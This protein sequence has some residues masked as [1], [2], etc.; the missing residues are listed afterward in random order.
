MGRPAMTEEEK[1]LKAKEREE[2]KKLEEEKKAKEEVETSKISIVQKERDD[3]CKKVVDE[4]REK[5]PNNATLDE[6]TELEKCILF[7]DTE[8]GILRRKVKEAKAFD[9][10]YKISSS[11]NT[12]T[13]KKKFLKTCSEKG[14]EPELALT[15]LAKGFAEEKFILQ[16]R[17]EWFI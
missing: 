6:L 14:I 5:Y 12:A 15:L 3:L 4:I 8:L 10:S 16:S 2:A 11:F 9:E 1:A 13:D 17:T 7:Q